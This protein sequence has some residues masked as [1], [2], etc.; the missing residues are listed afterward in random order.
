MGYLTDNTPPRTN[1]A[2]CLVLYI[3]GLRVIPGYYTA[4]ELGLMVKEVLPDVE[5][6]QFSDA[7]RVDPRRRPRS[8]SPTHLKVDFQFHREPDRSKVANYFTSKGLSWSIYNIP[9]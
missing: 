3:Y 1:V 9:S 7:R 8:D 5:D 2:D 6:W 4:D